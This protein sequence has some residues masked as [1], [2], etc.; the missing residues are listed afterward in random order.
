MAV[1][2]VIQ[3]TFPDGSHRWKFFT[4]GQQV[5]TKLEPEPFDE[6]EQLSLFHEPGWTVKRK[7]I[8]NARRAKQA[9]YEIARCN[10][11]IWQWFV[12]LTFDPLYVNRQD[13]SSC[14]RIVREF[15]KS[16]TDRGCRW[17]F[18]PEHHKDG[19][20]FHF[21]GLVS[22]EM[23]L[24]YAGEFG[25]GSKRRPTY[26]IPFFPGYTSVQPIE[27]SRKSSVYIT[28]YITKDLVHLVPKGCHRYLHSRSL[29]RPEV[30]YHSMTQSEFTAMLNFG[31]YF[32]S[33]HF[34]DGL[35]GARYFKKVPM[36]F[37]LNNE[38]M[39]IVED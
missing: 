8:E 12:T 16:L 31:E 5:G 36:Y 6:D 28:K 7:E 39:Y 3:Y 33:E 23:E 37:K 34:E 22:G 15:T 25:L 1:F 35:N 24:V 14:L 19:K 20:S 30:T 18:V 27:D 21:H 10:S 32:D 9:V 2:N 29:L 17:L 26:N 13:Y 11:D 38:F 4:Y